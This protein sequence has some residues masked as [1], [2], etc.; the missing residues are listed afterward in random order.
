MDANFILISRLHNQLLINPEIENPKDIVSWMGAIQA[1][2][3]NMGKWAV[4]SRLRKTTDK[5]IESAINSGDIIRLHIL[6]PTWHFVS[7]DDIHWMLDLSTPRL[8]VIGRSADKYFGFTSESITKTN[9]LLTSILENEPN[10]TRQEIGVRLVDRGVAVDNQSI[11]HIMFHAELDGIVCNGIVKN[12]KQTYDLLENRAPKKEKYNKDESLY[13]L[14]YKYFRSHGPATLQ[15][16]IWWSGLTTSEA[17]RGVESIKDEFI[18]EVID[19]QAFIFH[20]SNLNHQLDD[21][22]VHLLP[23]FDELFVSYKDR[24]EILDL[25]HHKKVIVSNGVFKPT[26][27][28]NGKI[29]GIWNRIVRKNRVFGE[30]SCF[31][32]PTKR[33]QKLIDQALLDY[34][35]YMNVF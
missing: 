28:Y 15:D 21:D 12:K 1:Q 13:K 11:N 27:F 26:V 18:T 16:F 2:D 17:K 30:V 35:K 22:M 31:K 8:K 23:A 24:K 32:E 20:N 19:G 34:D 6:R 7:K 29:I 14:A 5:E 3:F 10:L 9:L 25:E 4:G 33:V